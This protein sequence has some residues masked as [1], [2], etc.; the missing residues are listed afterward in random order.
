MS[1]TKAALEQRIAELEHQLEQER[2]RTGAL[3]EWF[4][5]EKQGG[6]ETVYTLAVEPDVVAIE[7]V[8][9][10]MERAAG[11]VVGVRDASGYLDLPVYLDDLLQ[12]W[13]QDDAAVIRRAA[14]EVQAL[15]AT[16]CAIK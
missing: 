6:P 8:I 3:A 16:S 11:G 2:R 12:R 10:G 4:F 13:R 9:R 15:R 5:C 7:L 1:R 14:A